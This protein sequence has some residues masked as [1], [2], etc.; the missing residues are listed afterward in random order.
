MSVFQHSS[1]QPLSVFSAALI[2][3]D[4]FFA[5]MRNYDDAIYTFK[6]RWM[7]PQKKLYG[8]CTP[9]LIPRDTPLIKA[10]ETLF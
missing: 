6:D 1:V 9:H 8:Y 7:A 3:E 2:M 5:D 4:Y 10:T